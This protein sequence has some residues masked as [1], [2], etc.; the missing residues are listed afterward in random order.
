MTRKTGVVLTAMFCGSVFFSGLN[1]AQKALEE[2]RA[3][4]LQ[5]WLDA[6]FGMMITWGAYSQAGG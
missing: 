5:W 4:Q 2:T 1:A 3:Q 6:R